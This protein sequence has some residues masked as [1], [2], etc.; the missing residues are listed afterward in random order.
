MISPTAYEVEL[1]SSMH[2]HP[3]FHIHL[4]KLY[5]SGMDRFPSRISIRPSVEEEQEPELMDDEQPAWEVETILKKRKRG[6][7]VEYL[8]KW[9]D[10]PIEEATWEPMENLQHAQESIQE[11]EEKQHHRNS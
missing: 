10:Y 2:I 11:Y 9:K 3:V 5:Q 6:R 8:I 7:Q 1:P 4:L